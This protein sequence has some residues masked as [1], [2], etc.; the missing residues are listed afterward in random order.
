MDEEALT[1][2][3]VKR[4]IGQQLK[5]KVKNKGGFQT[6]PESLATDPQLL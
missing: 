4:W 1:G 5:I 6:G 2:D 3:Q